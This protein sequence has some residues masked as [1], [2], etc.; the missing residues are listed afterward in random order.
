MRPASQTS[1]QKLFLSPNSEIWTDWVVSVRANPVG[2]TWPAHLA[3]PPPVTTPQSGPDE[4]QKL[5]GGG[6]RVG[7]ASEWARLQEAAATCGTVPSLAV[8]PEMLALQARRTR[9]FDDV[10]PP[11]P[12]PPTSQP[13]PAPRLCPCC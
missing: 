8:V 3:P 2:S 11:P 9:G 10:P 5:Q 7:G 12:P 4:L 6:D 1:P 13:P